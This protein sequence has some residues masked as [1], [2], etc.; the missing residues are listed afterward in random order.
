M[1]ASYMC[2]RLREMGLEVIPIAII[3]GL[4]AGSVVHANSDG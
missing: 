3:L 1:S 2:W 4:V